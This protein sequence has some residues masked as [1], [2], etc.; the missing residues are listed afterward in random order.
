[1][2]FSNENNHTNIILSKNSIHKKEHNIEFHLCHWEEKKNFSTLLD[3]V[4]KGL[5][6]K[7]TK[8]KSAEGR[9]IHMCIGPNKRN[10]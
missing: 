2:L 6:I 5:G 10:S 8:G 4:P 1:M 3:S 7:L 9:I